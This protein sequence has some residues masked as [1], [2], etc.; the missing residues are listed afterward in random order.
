MKNNNFIALIVGTG[1]CGTGYIAKCLNSSGYPRGHEGIFNHF[2]ESIVS[3]N[4]KRSSLVADSAWPAA[5]FLGRPW[6]SDSIKIV[7]LVRNPID[8]I[9]SFWE[10][11]FFSKDRVNKNL[12]QIVYRNTNISPYFQHRLS[13]SVKHYFYWNSLIE[14]RLESCN[15]PYIFTRLEDIVSSE[16][17]RERLCG[18]LGLNLNFPS[19]KI[20]EKNDFKS[21]CDFDIKKIYNQRDS[22]SK[23]FAR[24]QC[25]WIHEYLM[26]RVQK[27][28]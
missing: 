9:K 11:N 21:H 16:G 4:F 23:N 27:D 12:N 17:E 7:H 18:F 15:N 8:V 14:T 1:R 22:I 13:S 28:L 5:A 25:V 10:I 19:E 2:D 26:I 20:N 6:L 3:N 24:F